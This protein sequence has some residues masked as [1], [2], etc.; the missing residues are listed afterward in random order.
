MAA[1]DIGWLH[2]QNMQLGIWHVMDPSCWDCRNDA[3][4]TYELFPSWCMCF[5]HLSGHRSSKSTSF[6]G[7]IVNNK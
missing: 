5:K 6:I 3:D 2:M 7:N 4:C 1:E